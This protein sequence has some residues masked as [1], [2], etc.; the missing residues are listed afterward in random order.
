MR[1]KPG[2]PVSRA[3]GSSRTR[4]PTEAG[5]QSGWSPGDGTSLPQS[6]SRLGLTPR[7]EKAES[8]L[9]SPAAALRTGG[10]L[11]QPQQQQE[12][13]DRMNSCSGPAAAFRQ[14]HLTYK[15]MCDVQVRRQAQPGK[16]EAG[17]PDRPPTGHTA[18]RPPGAVQGQPQRLL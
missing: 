12:D 14:F 9:T 18:G 11:A 7:E 15:A 8:E 5:A 16:G 3:E 6:P 10:G 13:S 4:L 17:I 2:F 1:R